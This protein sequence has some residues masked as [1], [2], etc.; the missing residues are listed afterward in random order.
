VVNTYQL[1]KVG[2]TARRLKVCGQRLVGRVRAAE[3]DQDYSAV[4]EMS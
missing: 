4:C 3:P 2:R 1:A